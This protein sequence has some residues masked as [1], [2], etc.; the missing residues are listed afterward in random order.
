M[1]FP[2]TLAALAALALSPAPAF[3]DQAAP[4][5][6][7]AA[8]TWPFEASD[9]PVDPEFRFGVLDNGMRYILRQHAPPAGTAVVRLHIGS[10]S[11]DENENERGLAH[12]LEH[13]AFNGS[14]RV[15]EGEMVKLLER[16]GLAFGADTNASTGLEQT[17]YR[18][19]LPRNDPALLETV[20]MLMRETASE[21]LIEEG[22]VARERGIILAE[23]RDRTN[24]AYKALVDQ[25]DF[26]AP[27]AR[28]TA[29]LPIGALEVLETAGAAEL[30][31]FY[32]RNYVP[33][34]ATLVIAGDFPIELL[35]ARVRHW[36]AD[37]QSA[38][39]PVEPATGPIDLTRSGATDIHVDPALPESVSLFRYG[40][41]Q[42]RPDT[43][44]NRQQGILRQVGYGVIN[45][46]LQALAR[47]ADAPFRGASYG[48]GDLFEDARQTT[49]SVSSEDG[50]WRKGLIAAAIEVRRALAYG[51]SD[52]EVAEQVAQLRNALEEGARGAG[53]RTHNAL[54]SAAL[55][56]IDD[57]RIPSTPQSA[58]ERFENFVGQIT[59]ASTL[60]AV[61][62]D[63]VPLDDPLIRFQ[64]RAEPEGG[65]EA[66]RAAWNEAAAAQVEPPKAGAQL[67]FAY[68]DFGAPGPIVSDTRD[69]RLGIRLIRFA[70]GLRLNLKQTDI[71][72]DRVSFRLRLDGGEL[73]NTAEDPLRTALVSSLPGGGLGAH[74]QDELATILAGRSVGFAIGTTPDAFSLGGGTTP[75]DLELQMQLLA[76]GLTDPGYRSEGEERYRRNIA[77]FFASLDATPGQAL[78]NQAD[79]ILSDGD[80]RFTLQSREAY[81]SRSFAALAKDIG[82]RLANG[83]LELA[84]V[85]DFDE[86]A[87]IDAVARTLGALP[88]REPDFLPRAEARQRGF[89]AQRGTRIITHSGEAD[90]AL[91]Q[92]VWP[93][94]DDS[95]LREALR[96]E[97]LGRV[98][99]LRLQEVMREELGQA[100]SPSAQSTPSRV[101]RGYGTFSLTVAVDRSQ[102][103]AARTAIGRMLAQLRTGTLD[104]D[105]VNR[106]RQP[107]LEAYDNLLK[108]LGG[109]MTL[110]ERAQSEP[111]QIE[112]YFATPDLLKGITASELI[113]AAGRYLPA[114]SAVELLVV[115]KGS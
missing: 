68:T 26:A 23:R 79:G 95:D 28:F 61:L 29:R 64:G 42:D 10:G 82:D 43:V 8:T 59:P 110:V 39:D 13:M 105:T 52:A 3:A 108:S 109:W 74:S 71:R 103:D 100:Y 17:V 99:Q 48:T 93:T 87:A 60:Q 51:F 31:G 30:R 25:L 67:A 88:A 98:V 33:S 73:L 45:R 115:P 35:E 16:E 72:K 80:P 5:A 37:W 34:N 36:F 24:F 47:A 65:T 38:S 106:A 41:W 70:N 49:L 4:A 19:D 96:L 77:Q 44:A 78:A 32:R 1:R 9:V 12:F 46:R 40:P 104:A 89:T 22:A 75:R 114:E 53:T 58:L 94:T 18:L 7:A 20:L 85:G 11:L 66:L 107:M 92:L 6:Q 102:L 97:V 63:A 57:E 113:E 86:N 84:L 101:W 91:I 76:A 14:K 111:D 21:L 112:R 62:A 90:Q 50:Q 27:G 55:S 15:P 69:A 54:A 81:L 2:V 56:L 83:A